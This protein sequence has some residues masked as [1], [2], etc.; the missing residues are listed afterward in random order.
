ML[1]ILAPRARDAAGEDTPIT[2]TLRSTPVDLFARRALRWVQTRQGAWVLALGAQHGTLRLRPDGPDT[3]QV[4]QV[5]RDADPLL[6]G[7]TLPLGYAQG[8]AED[9]ARHLGVV[10]LVAAEAPWRQHP[11]TVLSDAQ[12]DDVVPLGVQRGKDAG[13]R[14]HR[15]RVLGAAPAEHQA[16]PYL[17]RRHRADPIVTPDRAALTLPRGT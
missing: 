11:A 14:H 10:R 13:C 5:R 8:L 15:D 4:I 16:D 1:A 6:L 7:D 3:W 17:V 9:Y 12:R 2:G